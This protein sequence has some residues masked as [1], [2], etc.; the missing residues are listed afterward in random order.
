MPNS[1]SVGDLVYVAR[2]PCCPG[3]L[4]YHFTVTATTIP[5]EQYGRCGHCHAQHSRAPVALDEH[6]IV[7][8]LEW[9][10]KVPPMT[11]PERVEEEAHV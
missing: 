10:R 7:F 11:E 3:R 6:Y 4:G 1:I 5:I 9:L 8:P 2:W